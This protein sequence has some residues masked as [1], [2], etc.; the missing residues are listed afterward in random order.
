MALN[1]R[2]EIVLRL[3]H[4]RAVD[5]EQRIAA[6]D[7][8]AD[9]GDQPGHAAGE[10]RQHGGAGVLVV[11]DLA[12]GELLDAKGIEL[13]LHDAELMHLVVG[14]P[15]DVAFFRCALGGDPG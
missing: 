12:D 15:D 5:L 6:L 1:G 7:L 13:H 3:H 14:D 2:D 11:G 10:R 9:L 8:V 4:F